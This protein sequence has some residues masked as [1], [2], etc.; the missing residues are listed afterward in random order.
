MLAYAR[1]G[2]RILTGALALM[3][4][5]AFSFAQEP[6]ATVHPW[7]LAYAK[8]LADERLAEKREKKER[9]EHLRKLARQ[10]KRGGKSALRARGERARPAQPDDL[11]AIHAEP[12][13]AR[14]SA[15]SFGAQ[16]FTP[17]ANHIANNRAGDVGDAGQSE[18]SIAAY[19]DKVVAAWNDGQGFQSLTADT[20]GWATSIDGGLTWADR[21][22]FPSTVPG[23]S[24][25]KWTSD[26]VLTVNEK[27]G[28]FYF[29][30]LCDFNDT[31]GS[32][33][34]VAVTK[35]RWNGN[36]FAWGTP[37]IARGVSDAID[38]V[39]K[40]WIV[41]DSVSDRVF[42]SYSRFPSGLSRIEFQYADSSLS[43]FS[44]PQ[45]L[46]LNTSIENGFVQASRPIVDGDGRLFVMYYLI[47]QGESDFYRLCRSDNSGA[48]FTSPV[49]AESLFTNFGTGSPGF[50]RPIGIQF[51][52]IS[53]D[54]SH[55]PHRGR[56]YLSW[57]E[58]IDWLDDVFNIGLS[59][60]KSEIEPNNLTSNATP[61]VVGQTLRGTVT[62]TSDVDVYAIPLVAGQHLIAAAD[63]TQAINELSLRLLA[64]DGL[65]GLTFTTFDATVNPTT[66]SPQGTPSGLAVHGADLRHVL[67]AHRFA[68]RRGDRQLPH[69]HRARRPRR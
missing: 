68:G 39:D 34:G 42:L 65:T 22:T 50:N 24:S 11:P 2:A 69:P 66:Q 63:S 62:T 7:K 58:S 57:A 21:D 18:T 46:S 35:G 33:S 51:A 52:G 30:A 53:V 64:E 23:V 41:A 55:G 27:T 45:L 8:R 67:P 44:T 28:A 9:D 61:A 19:G 60:N 43:A 10:L 49:T 31:F 48:S 1:I 4:L 3:L 14:R 25:F 32:R 20:Q 26:P 37:V 38:F 13:A 40:E 15:R 54:R 59:G 36:A 5:P 16:S 6:A 47:G 12:N 56:L 29:A 17:P